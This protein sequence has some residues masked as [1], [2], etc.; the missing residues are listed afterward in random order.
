MPNHFFPPTITITRNQYKFPTALSTTSDQPLTQITSPGEGGE[1]KLQSLENLSTPLTTPYI[2]T[3]KRIK[4]GKEEKEAA[5]KFQHPSLLPA[6]ATVA[7]TSLCPRINLRCRKSSSSTNCFVFVQN[8]WSDK[9]PVSLYFHLNRKTTICT[10]KIFI[11]ISSLIIFQNHP[12]ELD[13][14]SKSVMSFNSLQLNPSLLSPF[15]LVFV[16]FI[17]F[18][19]VHV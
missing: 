3:T 12:Q 8:R 5:S 4:T 9:E 2:A 14:N 1:K 11:K 15:R 6:L 13:N 10:P 19:L 18:N 16:L 17:F 7:A